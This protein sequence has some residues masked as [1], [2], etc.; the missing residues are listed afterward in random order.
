[1]R[2]PVQLYVR[3]HMGASVRCWLHEPTR[4]PCGL[5]EIVAVA[6]ESQ[7]AARS[8]ADPWHSMNM[9]LIHCV[10][11]QSSSVRTSMK[12]REVGNTAT[13]VSEI[14]FGGGGN[15]GL[16][17]RGSAEEQRQAIARALDLGINYFDQSPDY[18]TGLSETNLGRVLKDLGVRPYITTKVEVREQNLDDIAG[19]VVRSVDESLNRLGVDYVDF[20]QIHNGP[21]TTRPQLS[22][23]T[24]THLWI[25]DYLRPGGALE[26]LQRVQRAGKARFLGFITRGNDAPAARQLIDTG[27]FSLINASVNLLNPSAALKPYGMHVEQD[28]DRILTYAAAHGV[29][30]AVYSPLAGWFLTN[31]AVSGSTPHALASGPR[32]PES[33]QVGLRRAKA[34][35]FLSSTLHPDV[36]R[37]DHNLAEA[38][39]RFVLSLE[40]VSVVL[41]GFSDTHQVEEVAGCSGRGPL[42]EENLMRVEGIWRSNFGMT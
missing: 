19:H 33:E 34:L 22:G 38:A 32:T 9:A 13:R 8:C 26:G 18:G 5:P 15:A 35:G 11:W 2:T 37:D 21:V 7:R 3:R 40:G 10:G 29:G 25:E 4:G 17:V 16:M 42:S 1:M 36:Q 27:C 28:Y 31:G 20:L 39:I 6:A 23:R 41:G 24:Y 12:Y 14:G 30:A